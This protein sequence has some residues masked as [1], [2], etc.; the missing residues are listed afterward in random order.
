MSE[1]EILKKR[2]EEQETFRKMIGI[3]C[4]GNHHTKKGTLCED[5][6]RLEKYAHQRTTHCPHMATKTFCANCETPCY[7]KEYREKI[8]VM[9][10]YAG[11]RMIF[12][13]PRMAVRHMRMMMKQ[14][15][16]YGH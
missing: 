2:L 10:K 16:K 1:E 9:M 4:H 15:R 11:S 7:K 13:A 12:H 14:R 8:R 5:C 3:Y 6:A